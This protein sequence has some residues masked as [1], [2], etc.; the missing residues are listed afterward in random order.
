MRIL[1]WVGIVLGVVVVL[2]FST[3]MYFKSAAKARYEKTYTIEVKPIPMPF[4]LTPREVE[5]LRAQLEKE[6]KG[7][8]PAAEPAATP[9]PSEPSAEAPAEAAPT[10]DG[11]APAAEA[12]PAAAPQADVL[13]GVDLKAIAKERAI[14]RGKGYV[15]SRA[16]CTECHGEDFGGKVIIDSPVMGTWIAPNIT[17]G[18]VTAEYTSVDWVRLLRHGVKPNNKPASMPCTDFT[19]FSDQ[20]ISDIALYVNSV[21]KVDRVM[22]DSTF[23]PIF[24]MLITQGEIPISAEVIDHT[25]ERPK[26]PPR[27][28]V[29]SVELGKHLATT[30]T[31]C[32]GP[33]L[34]GGPIR[35]GDP[36]WGP[37][38]N[39]TFHET[40][41]ATW[42]PEQ[43]TKALR[44]GVRP[45]GS[46]IL[47]PMPTAYTARLN[48]DEIQSLYDY[49]KTL[50][51]TAFGNH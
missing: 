38:R 1:K 7:K 8:T 13:E 22:P 43:F 51:P 16:G 50:P 14:E 48:D 11:A 39:L 45:D 24:S 32:H 23:G 5:K 17:R 35:G 40:G 34:S 19:W 26:Y 49:L 6:Q 10:A 27:A 4:P 46:P 15:E 37:A 30:C 41:L 29:V 2:L 42:T 9:A 3:V 12:A 25:A 36:S 28:D 20:E 18:G 33:G 21:P 31:G 47:P 44:E